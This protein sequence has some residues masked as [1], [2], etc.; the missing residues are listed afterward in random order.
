MKACPHNTKEDRNMSDKKTIT[1]KAAADAYLEHLGKNGTKE[2]TVKVYRRSLDLAITHFKGNRKLSTI[3]PPHVGGY[4]ASDLVNKHEN[5]K[6]K[7]E[8]TIKQNKR[9]FRQC[10]EFAKEQ[11]WINILPI[12]KTEMQ[13]ARSKKTSP[14]PE[15]PKAE[16]TKKETA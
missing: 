5:G 12:P 1:L 8:P 11:G 10:K 7:A 14:E 4:F 15:T 9:V 3:T 16:S 2:T 13:H 6:P